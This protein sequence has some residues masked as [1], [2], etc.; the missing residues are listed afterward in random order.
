MGSTLQVT[1]I[2]TP[3]IAAI[4]GGSDF[5]QLYFTIHRSKFLIGDFIN[6]VHSHHEDATLLGLFLH[7]S[8]SCLCRC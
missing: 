7:A 3:L 4:Y 1:D 6:Q 5:S 2:L 8:L